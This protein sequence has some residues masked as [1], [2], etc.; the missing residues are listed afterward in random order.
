MSNEFRIGDLVTYFPLAKAS[1]IVFSKSRQPGMSAMAALAMLKLF[2][3]NTG[4][5]MGVI[6]EI[7][8]HLGMSG[9]RLYILETA[10]GRVNTYKEYLTLITRPEP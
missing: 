2:E 8:D 1:E 9:G 5:W 4:E 6:V 7:S 10:T 3:G